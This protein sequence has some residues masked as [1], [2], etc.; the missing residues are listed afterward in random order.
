MITQ[1]DIDSLGPWTRKQQY[2]LGARR[3][4]NGQPQV[5]CHHGRASTRTAPNG[6]QGQ[7]RNKACLNQRQGGGSG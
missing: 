7:G 2:P 6:Y 1:Q 5:Y 3:I 4:R